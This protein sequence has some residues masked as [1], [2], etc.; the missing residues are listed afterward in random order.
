M[1]EKI[2]KASNLKSKLKKCDSEI[3]NYVVE[4]KKENSKLHREIV[5]IQVKNVSLNNRVKA[6]EKEFKGKNINLEL[7][8]GLL[9]KWE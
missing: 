6:L 2:Q 1:N 4:L 8:P 5:K 3:K 9:K 7:P